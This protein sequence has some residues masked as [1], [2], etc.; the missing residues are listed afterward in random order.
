MIRFRRRPTLEIPEDRWVRVNTRH[1]SQVD[2]ATKDLQLSNGSWVT[3]H[4]ED[5]KMVQGYF[6]SYLL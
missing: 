5:W 3:V 2:E 4:P 6:W 1:I